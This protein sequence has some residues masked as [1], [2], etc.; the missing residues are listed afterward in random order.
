MLWL[1]RFNL[2]IGR[3]N[4]PDYLSED[5]GCRDGDVERAQARPH[6]NRHTGAGGAV[7]L[8]GNAGRFP[9]EQEDVV[10][11]EGEGRVRKGAF[12]GGEDETM[13]VLRPPVLEGSPRTVAGD[14]DLVEVVEP[15]AAEVA[16]GDVEAGRLDDVDRHAEAGREAQ[17]RARILRDVRLIKSEARHPA[18][19]IA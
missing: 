6:R 17:H 7:H 15:G 3:L 1:E 11:G 5:H 4:L 18:V 2:W 12:G 14:L 10:A 19:M 13:P 16:V 8:I 9:A